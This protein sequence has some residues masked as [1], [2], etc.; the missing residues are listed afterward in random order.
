MTIKKLQKFGSYLC[1]RCVRACVCSTRVRRCFL[2]RSF[3]Q[4][5]HTRKNEFLVCTLGFN[6]HAQCTHGIRRGSKNKTRWFKDWTSDLNCPVRVQRPFPLFDGDKNI[7]LWSAFD[8]IC[9]VTIPFFSYYSFNLYFY[10]DNS[11]KC[12]FIKYTAKSTRK[13]L[14]SVTQWHDIE[15]YDWVNSSKLMGLT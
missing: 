5:P 10:I 11:I 2:L 3:D 9:I 7:K 15:C 8:V 4:T 1:F 13:S 14:I 12:T 6:A